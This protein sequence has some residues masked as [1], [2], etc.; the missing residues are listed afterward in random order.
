MKRSLITSSLAALSVAFL[1]PMGAHAATTTNATAAK[2]TTAAK[3][4]SATPAKNATATKTHRHTVA[5]NASAAK[6]TKIDINTAT[7]EELMTL[8]GI[9]G[10]MA[11]K[12]IA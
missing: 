6:P 4:E 9:D 11:D 5:K 10:D 3:T 12:I 1:L 8:P 2:H 7:R